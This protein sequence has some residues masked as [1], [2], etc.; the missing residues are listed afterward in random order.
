[1]GR[2]REGEGDTDLDPVSFVAVLGGRVSEPDMLGDV[3]GRQ[4]DGPPPI[5]VVDGYRAVGP[6]AGHLPMVLVVYGLTPVGDELPVVATGDHDVTHVRVLAATDW[7]RGG[8][9]EVAGVEVGVLDRVIQG[10]DV[11]LAAGRD[12]H[13]PS[14]GER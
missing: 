3:P 12:R 6:G 4:R 8:R 11:L 5:G 7:D 2:G 1:V 13:R 14:L 9:V 10:V